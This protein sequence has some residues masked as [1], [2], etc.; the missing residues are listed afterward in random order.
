MSKSKSY[1]DP[2]EFEAMTD[3]NPYRIWREGPILGMKR[4][5]VL[6]DRCV[7]CNEPACGY[8]RSVRLTYRPT[9]GVP[10]FA[11]MRMAHF[12]IASLE[13]WTAKIDIGLCPK[14]RARRKH[15]I[16]AAWLF[17]LLSALMFYVSASPANQPWSNYALFPALAF[18]SGAVFAGAAV[19]HTV[20]ARE[21]NETSIWLRNVHPKFLEEFPDLLGYVEDEPL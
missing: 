19:S 2:P 12:L 11:L 16:W 9:F 13:G 20:V 14:H 4:F 5:A 15:L 17:G 8:S 1:S 18:L 10:S 3:D 21:M 7:S 6:P